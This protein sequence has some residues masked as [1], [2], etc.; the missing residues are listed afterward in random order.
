MKEPFLDLLSKFMQAYYSSLKELVLKSD[1]NFWEQTNK[2]KR[3]FK[4]RIP[5]LT[6]GKGKA[7]DCSDFR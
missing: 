2:I 3:T 7:N 1:R 5:S 4:G 6:S